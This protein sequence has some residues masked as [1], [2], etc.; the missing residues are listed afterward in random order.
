MVLRLVVRI[1][2]GIYFQRGHAVAP[3]WLSIITAKAKKVVA[4]GHSGRCLN[5][6]A[7]HHAKIDSGVAMI[8]W[9]CAMTDML[10]VM[11]PCDAEAVRIRTALWASGSGGDDVLR[12]TCR[13]G[14]WK[15]HTRQLD[16]PVGLPPSTRGRSTASNG[17]RL[18]GQYCI[19]T[20]FISSLPSWPRTALDR[21][22]RHPSTPRRWAE[23]MP[24]F[25]DPGAALPNKS[26]T[27]TRISPQTR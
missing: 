9:H 26:Y 2:L 8:E 3:V 17:Q 6:W 7:L 25:A 21:V 22:P 27:K 11:Y 1:V 14:G 13:F 15:N 18:I 12:F 23:L 24:P 20:T 5:L 10:A 16:P 4:E 19:F